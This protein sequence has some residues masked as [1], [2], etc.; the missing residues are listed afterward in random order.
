[1]VFGPPAFSGA[2][3]GE[4][5]PRWVPGQAECPLSRC[6]VLEAGGGPGWPRVGAQV[7]WGSQGGPVSRV[8]QTLAIPTP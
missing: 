1:M 6:R 5:H 8:Q 3:G 4:G 7:F 2:G